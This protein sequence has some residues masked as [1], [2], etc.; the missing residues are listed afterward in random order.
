VIYLPVLSI[1]YLMRRSVVG[2]VHLVVVISRTH[3]DTPHSLG[4]F[5]TSDQLVSVA[6]TYATNDKHKTRTSMLL[7]G[8]ENAVSPINRLYTL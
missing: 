3:T 6:A 7:A 8:F 2:Q 1:A 5:L 4:L